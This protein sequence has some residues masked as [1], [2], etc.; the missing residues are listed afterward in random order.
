VP[1]A[2]NILIA[3]GL[4]RLLR[5]S[6]D[7]A[8]RLP[9][10]DAIL[11]KVWMVSLILLVIE[12][13]FSWTFISDWYFKG[14]YL[15]ILYTVYQL[16]DYR[17]AWLFALALAP[18]A[19]ASGV[20]YVFKFILPGF[21]ESLSVLFTTAE[22]FSIMWLI[23]FS[24]Y[25]FVQNNKE[26]KQQQQQEAQMLLAEAKKSELEY[27]VK[28]RTLELTEQKKELEKALVDLKSMQDQLVQHEKMASLGELTA[29]IAHEIQNPLNFVNNFAEVSGEL[30]TEM[31]EA[32]EKGD[33]EE[34]KA[35]ADD[36]KQNLEKIN[37]HGHRASSI[38]RGMLGHAR[39]DTGKKEVT[40]LNA[41][42]DECL[43]LSFHGMRAKDRSFD[44][45][46]AQQLDPNLPQVSIV[47]QDMGRVL[48]NLF[49]NAFYA[50]MKKK[51]HYT[52][53]TPYKPLVY[54]SSAATANGV[55]IRVRDN[56]IGVPE[57]LQ[58][59]IFQPFFTTKPAGEGTGLGLS[60]SYDIITKGHSG[61]LHI[62]SQEGEGATFI[63]QIPVA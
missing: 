39:T 18:F 3:V 22:S 14:V 26:K 10:W 38:V 45:N 19:V 57:S 32:L 2:I 8:Q 63:I 61:T 24:I 25:A 16:R 1:F 47:A 51:E 33:A 36:L 44:V 60:L 35:I 13:A 21:H 5:K 27:L 20:S 58:N 54:V 37:H 43:R 55:E 9:Q 42:I 23:G 56:G 12:S 49:N 31:Q 53:T 46:F 34:V 4:I 28:E 50:T 29:G 59:K 6:A 41:L 48:L 62:E 15:I 52:G 17:P 40:D 11:S 30:I 7:T